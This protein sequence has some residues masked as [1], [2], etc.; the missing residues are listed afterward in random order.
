[1]KWL[2]PTKEWIL[3]ISRVIRSR[4]IQK[5]GFK[6]RG[7]GNQSLRGQVLLVLIIGADFSK[8]M[9]GRD[10][11]S[12]ASG[13]RPL[14]PRGA[15]TRG[16]DMGRVCAPSP[17]KFLAEINTFW[18][19]F[20]AVLSPIE[21]HNYRPTS[22]Y[23]VR[24]FRPPI[25][26]SSSPL[27]DSVWTVWLQ[28]YHYNITTNVPHTPDRL[29]LAWLVSEIWGGSQNKKSES[30]WFPETPPSGQIRMITGLVAYLLQAAQTNVG[31]NI[32]KIK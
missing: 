21:M 18:W 9:R 10:L 19:D 4:S 24:R 25:Q 31:L 5:F 7:G 28:V 32:G 17:E 20:D 1:V 30:S 16:W 15:T 2:T 29:W 27:T 8:W 22:R 14:R 13:R 26:S 6:S 3:Y 11:S 12:L 23:N